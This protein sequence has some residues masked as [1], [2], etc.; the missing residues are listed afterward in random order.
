MNRLPS[1]C[2]ALILLVSAL[3][4]QLLAQPT[5]IVVE[6]I[7]DNIGMVGT[8]DL[9]GYSTYRVYVKFSHPDDFLSAVAG[10]AANGPVVI[11][12]GNN[13][14]QDPLGGA[15]PEFNNPALFAAFPSLEYDSYVTIGIDGPSQNYPGTAGVSIVTDE[16]QPW[17]ETFE[18]GNDLIID[19]PIGGA[20]FATY[21]YSNGVAGPDSLVLIGQFT[22]DAALTGQITFQ[23]FIQGQQGEQVTE[24]S[25]TILSTLAFSSIPDAIFGCVDPDAENTTP[26]ANTDDGSCVYACDYPAT[27][28]EVVSTEA[29]APACV[30]FSNGQASVEVIGGQGGVTY[31][32]GNQQ[33]ATGIFNNLT[34]G[35]YTIMA[36]DGQGCS[37]EAMVEVPE[38][39]ALELDV[40]VSQPI[41]CT[42]E[43]DAVIA[44]TGTGG[45][46]DLQFSLSAPLYDASGL[47]FETATDEPLFDG[48]GPGIYSVYTL[49]GNGCALNSS[50]ILVAEPTPFNV[51]AQGVFPASC[52]ASQDGV[53]V[54]NFFGGIGNSTTYSI[55]GVNYSSENI[56]HVSPGTYTFYAQDVNGCPDTLSNV[57]VEGSGQL[58][59]EVDVTPPSCAGGADGTVLL[60]PDGGSSVFD[61]QFNGELVNVEVPVT[62]LSAGTYSVYVS[63]DTGCEAEFDVVVDDLPEVT[64]EV[65][66]LEEAPCA[67][68]TGDIALTAAGGVGP[69]SVEGAFGNETFD[70][71]IPLDGIPAG[72]GMVTI[73]DA[74]GCAATAP[75]FID[76]PSA[77]SVELGSIQP[78]TPGNS[79]GSITVDL[80][81]G[82]PPYNTFWTRDDG[83]VVSSLQNPTGL[84][85]GTY[86]LSVAD[87]NGCT[88]T[89]PG[90]VVLELD[91]EGCTDVLALNFSPG[92]TLDD[93]S[94]IYPGCEDL[95]G[96]EVDFAAVLPGTL[97]GTFGV[98]LEREL[99]LLAGNL[100]V[101]PSTGTQYTLLQ[102]SPDTAFGLPAGLDLGNVNA[103]LAA[104]ETLCLTLDGTPLETGSFEVTIEGDMAVSVFGLPFAAGRTAVSFAIEILDNPNPIAGCTYPNAANYLAFAT[105]DDGSCLIPGCLDPEAVNHSPHFNVS[106]DSCVYASDF[107]GFGD[108]IFCRADFDASGLVGASD[109]LIFLTAF[110]GACVE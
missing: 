43:E 20:W 49:D 5:G 57:V 77:L 98:V 28:L 54:L 6:T 37:V 18:Q 32:L 81:G 53:V 7:S 103:D 22:T 108:D 44:G 69:Y 40:F 100:V 76:E 19:S 109:L 62:G 16:D 92:A 91:V 71:D 52:E 93:G 79:E 82:T 21:I 12:G 67:G 65:W 9:T 85:A 36:T 2:L 11:E 104:G 13:F 17:S 75:Y 89:V 56:F 46:G 38:A 29:V 8:T 94:C 15:T 30:G 99:L 78:T 90:F 31:G 47:Y 72:S 3:P 34:A 74:N 64:L 68:G 101:E 27:Q 61:V 96:A 102:F 23:T 60:F 83:V 39:S 105:V 70:L 87:A 4:P 35:A 107:G 45:A 50:S 10:D 95:E 1:F 33:N 55:D 59:L 84:M 25:G 63:D 51:Y 24:T 14:Y 26:G 88:L 73:V 42:G 48:L 97:E 58:E 86:S 110:E 66:V 106:D 80:S 41:S